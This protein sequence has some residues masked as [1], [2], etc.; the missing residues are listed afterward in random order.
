MSV[1]LV[2]ERVYGGVPHTFWRVQA[3]TGIA[4]TRLA[5]KAWAQR[6]GDPQR[7]GRM[8]Y[9][10]ASTWLVELTS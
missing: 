3:P 8:E 1:V 9:E 6:G 4:A 5:K 7:V 2:R 10:G